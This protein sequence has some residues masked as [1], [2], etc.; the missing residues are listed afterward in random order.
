MSSDRQIEEVFYFDEA[1]ITRLYNQ[2]GSENAESFTKESGYSSEYS[3]GVKPEVSS[4]NLWSNLILNLKIA[5]ELAGK[6]SKA[7]K[8]IEAHTITAEQRYSFLLIYLTKSGELKHGLRDGWLNALSKGGKSFCL[9]EAEFHPEPVPSNDWVFEANERKTLIL[10]DAN[11]QYR[12]GMGFA[13]LID[14]R[15]DRLYHDSHTAIRMRHGA[16]IRVLGSVDRGR[17][18]KPYIASWK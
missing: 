14:V 18:V 5:S 3:G 11:R 1:G 6:R 15:T 17:Y 4:G 7:V 9:F 8:L 13:S 12:M 16:K 10:T 2:I